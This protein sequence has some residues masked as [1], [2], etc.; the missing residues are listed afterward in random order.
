MFVFCSYS[1]ATQKKC[2]WAVNLF[3][4]W[5]YWR[6]ERAAQTADDQDTSPIHMESL[7]MMKDEL[8]FSLRP[9]KHL[10]S[11]TLR[12]GYM[13]LWYPYSCILLSTAEKWHFWM[14]QSLLCSKKH[15]GYENEGSDTARHKRS[16]SLSG[17]YKCWGRRQNVE[18]GSP[19]G[20]SSPKASRHHFI[21][22][23]GPFCSES[24][25]WASQFTAYQFSDFPT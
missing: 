15:I 2:E 12:K 9:R 17:D 25:D 21:H 20:Y 1:K 10:E 18:Y 11:H 16:L 8:C 19:W 7:D 23:W 6:N 3:N 14:T 13:K 22:V 24:G 5:K 4:K